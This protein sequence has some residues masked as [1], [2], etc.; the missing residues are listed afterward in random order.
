MQAK[1]MT[2]VH[3]TFDRTK[4]ARETRP[5]FHGL[6]VS[7]LRSP[8]EAK[9]VANHAGDNGLAVG[10]HFPLVRDAYPAVGLHPWLTSRDESL[11]T[12]G[13]EAIKRDLDAA[14]LVGAEYLVVHY[15][16]PAVVDCNLEWSDWR[17]TQDGEAIDQRTTSPSEQADLSFAAFDWLSHLASKSPVQLVVEHDILNST[18]YE[19]MDDG[20]LLARLLRQY[21]DLGLCVDTGR[22][23]LLENTDPGFDALR[24]TSLMMPYVTN[25]HLWTARVGTNRFGEHHPVHPDLRKEEGWGEMHGLLRILAELE[26]IYVMFEHNADL[27]PDGQLDECYS[28]VASLLSG[29]VSRK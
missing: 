8:E 19:P 18:H 10:V 4:V 27:L 20:A 29:S 15:P 2:G 1:F 16:K 12:A 21:P 24:F 23:H 14:L 13:F 25:V 7:C 5:G 6:E 17:F 26:N 11:R 9:A 3:G 22:L 28:W